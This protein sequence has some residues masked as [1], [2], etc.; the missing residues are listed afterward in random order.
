MLAATIANSCRSKLKITEYSK[1]A[2]IERVETETTKTNSSKEDLQAI[3][4]NEKDVLLK[5]NQNSGEIQI[6]GKTD[7]ANDFTYY[8]VQNGDTLQAISINGNADF[9]FRNK[10]NQEDKK[11]TVKEKTEEVNKVAKVV[12]ETVS[13]KT[14]KEVAKEAKHVNTKV[15][16]TGFPFNIY[17][18][19]VIVVIVLI[20]IWYFR[21]LIGGYIPNFIKKMFKNGQSN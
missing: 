17:V 8:N 7:S 4:K 15:K 18:C 12:R 2:E 20:L 13:Q 3:K 16:S 19:G 5:H 11:E 6:N 10:W 1:G 9:I 21:N 14:I